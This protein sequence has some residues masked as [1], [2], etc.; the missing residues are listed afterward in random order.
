MKGFRLA[1]LLYPLNVDFKAIVFLQSLCSNRKSKRGDNTLIILPENRNPIYMFGSVGNSLKSTENFDLTKMR[2]P[3]KNLF[4][5]DF[6]K[7][8]VV[9]GFSSIKFCIKCSKHRLTLGRIPRLKNLSLFFL[10]RPTKSLLTEACLGEV[11][12][13]Q[14]VES[15]QLL[16]SLRR[17]VAHP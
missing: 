13:L 17:S 12:A 8:P 14:R 2:I 1:L 9:K 16:I 4:T 6:T 7:A 15:L 5:L 3:N 10:A 11:G